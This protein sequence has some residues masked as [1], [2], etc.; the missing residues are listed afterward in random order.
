MITKRCLPLIYLAVIFAVATTIFSGFWSF[1]VWL[2]GRLISFLRNLP[3]E[4]PQ[5]PGAVLSPAD[6]GVI[7]VERTRDPYGQR[8]AILISLFMSVFNE[9]SNIS[10][11]DGK[12]ERVQYFPGKWLN[13]DQSSLQNERNA[14]VMTTTDKQTVTFVQIAGLIARRILCFVKAGDIL[15]RG[16]R[17]GLIR[18]GSRVDIYLP[19]DANIR[20][21]IGD[22]VSATT[23][24]LAVLAQN[25]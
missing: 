21:S 8:D 24:I 20:V 3:R 22:K 14:M 5:I 1:L 15:K 11:V 25:G 9:H 18:F 7:R 12:I 16:Q 23:T 19:L 10:P 2:Y 4:I 17:Y 13:L 6:G